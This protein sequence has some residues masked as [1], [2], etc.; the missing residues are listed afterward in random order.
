MAKKN[1]RQGN[2]LLEYG[3][4]YNGIVKGHGVY[5]KDKTIRGKRDYKRSEAKPALQV[6]IPGDPERTFTVYIGHQR[7]QF[8]HEDEEYA[9]RDRI[10]DIVAKAR[11]LAEVGD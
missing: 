11:T 9:T 5:F 7:V 6:M 10:K 1:K 4:L 3:R 2:D 8:D